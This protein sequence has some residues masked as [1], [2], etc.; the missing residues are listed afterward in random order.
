MNGSM[1]NYINSVLYHVYEYGCL[2][3]ACMYVWMMRLGD[4]QK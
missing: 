1:P 2:N 3:H 4:C